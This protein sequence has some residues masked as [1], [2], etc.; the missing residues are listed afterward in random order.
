[1]NAKMAQKIVTGEKIPATIDEID[2]LEDIIREIETLIVTASNSKQFDVNIE[3]SL[4][5]EKLKSYFELSGF[6]FKVLYYLK[7][8]YAIYISWYPK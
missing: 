6:K 8:P 3:Y 7:K 4:K 1:M 5:K 2:G